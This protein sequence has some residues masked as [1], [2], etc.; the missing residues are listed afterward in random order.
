VG[1]FDNFRSSY[2]LGE[3]TNVQCQTKSL[4]PEMGGTLSQY[5]L[6]P[7]GMLYLI[8]YSNTANFV[9]VCDNEGNVK[10]YSFVPNGNHGTVRFYYM[11]GDVEIYPESHTSS[12]E[13]CPRARLHFL[14]G[15]LQNACVS[16]LREGFE[17]F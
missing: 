6:A 12:W 9:P 4:D 17:G 16:T 1:F 10:N 15:M 8:D 13:D 14:E 7:N 3:L 11:T 2:D 5:W